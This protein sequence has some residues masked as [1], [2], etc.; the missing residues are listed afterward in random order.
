MPHLFLFD[1]LILLITAATTAAATQHHSNSNSNSHCNTTAQQQQQQ[2]PLQQ[3]QQQHQQQ[4]QQLQQ[5]LK[6]QQQ[7]H[8]QQLPISLFLFFSIYLFLILSIYLFFPHH[9][10]LN[11]NASPEDTGPSML[12]GGS[13]DSALTPLPP[14]LVAPCHLKTQALTARGTTVQAPPPTPHSRGPPLSPKQLL[15]GTGGRA[16]ASCLPLPPLWQD[17]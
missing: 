13:G 1:L 14:P 3:Q 12:P 16:H 2:Q 4:Q 11:G 9:P 6:L 15:G 17:G 7:Q 5:Q 8:Q 10:P